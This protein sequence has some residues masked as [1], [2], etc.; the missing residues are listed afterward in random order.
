M[1]NNPHVSHPGPFC[2]ATTNLRPEHTQ[3]YVLGSVDSVHYCSADLI[4]S[5]RSQ[6]PALA[7]SVIHPRKDKNVRFCLVTVLVNEAT[8]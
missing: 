5:L 1:E 2:A 6:E 4:Y 3:A 7:R 8:M